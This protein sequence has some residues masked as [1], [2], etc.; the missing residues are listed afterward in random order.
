MWTILPFRALLALS[1]TSCSSSENAFTGPPND[2]EPTMEP[3]RKQSSQPCAPSGL[4]SAC[5]VVS[6]SP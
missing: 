3:G 6:R 1:L 2:A 5:I 4:L